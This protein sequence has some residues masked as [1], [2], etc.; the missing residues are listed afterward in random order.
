MSNADL[1][2]AVR[3]AETGGAGAVIDM[4]GLGAPTSGDP[5]GARGRRDGMP[6]RLRDVPESVVRMLQLD[7]TEGEVVRLE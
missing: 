1:A 4:A 7:P 6:V 2:D 5:A 3:A